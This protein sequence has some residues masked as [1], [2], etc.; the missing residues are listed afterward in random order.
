MS[1]TEHM[2]ASWSGML[3][4]SPP[5][6][7]STRP[8]RRRSLDLVTR[9]LGTLDSLLPFVALVCSFIGRHLRNM[10]RSQPEK[11]QVLPLAHCT[12][13]AQHWTIFNATMMRHEDPSF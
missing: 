12:V 13:T 9:V 2:L 7:T 11:C 3:G 8:S 10:Q 1:H 5:P 6:P 4:R